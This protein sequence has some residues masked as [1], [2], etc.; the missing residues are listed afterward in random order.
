VQKDLSTNEYRPPARNRTVWEFE[1]AEEEMNRQ[2]KGTTAGGQFSV[3]SRGENPLELLDS[4]SHAGPTPRT[5]LTAADAA[6]V[7]MQYARSATVGSDLGY[8]DGPYS[9]DD[10]A[11]DSLLSLLVSVRNKTIPGL[12]SG[13]I[14]VAVRN[15][16]AAA[17]GKQNGTRHEDRA[18]QREFAIELLTEEESLGRELDSTEIDELA[19]RVRDTWPNSTHRPRLGFHQPM[20]QTVSLSEPGVSIEAGNIISAEPA[21]DEYQRPEFLLDLLQ[22]GAISRT[23]AQRLAWNSLAAEWD[24]PE[25]THGSVSGT[26]SRRARRFVTAHP[27]GV[28]EIARRYLIDGII[29]PAANALFS[30]FTESTG[31]TSPLSRKVICD[32]LTTNRRTADRMWLSASLYAETTPLSRRSLSR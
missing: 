25:A 1:S 7:A 12:T 18:G 3:R 22:D 8:D 20:R 29:T 30:P 9:E 19:A 2:P 23:A 28:S 4:Y 17:R 14:A 31:G 26:A 24:V 32:A 13:L 27:G 21:R 6:R 15:S 16:V 10:I 5:I 11:Q